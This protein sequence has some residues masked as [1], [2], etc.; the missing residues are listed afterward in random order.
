MGTIEQKREL[1]SKILG[2]SGDVIK[3]VFDTSTDTIPCIYLFTINTVGKLRKSMNIDPKYS[4]DMFLCKYGFTADLGR[5]TT[6]HIKTY[7]AIKNADLK[8]KYFRYIDPMYIS[9][10][11]TDI[12]TYFKTLKVGFN[13]EKFEELVVI[14]PNMLKGI[15]TQ[16]NMLGAV[17]GGHIKTLMNDIENMKNQMKILR[18]ENELNLSKKDNDISKKDNELNLSK[19]EIEL[20]IKDIA[21]LKKDNE[22]LTS[23]LEIERLKNK[24]TEK[25][26][27]R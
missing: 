7:N 21:L 24:Q 25:K 2:V 11:E 16:Y 27:K 10:A 18:I 19:K 4:D 9:N 5:R 22:I 20:L 14:E 15:K 3:E 1:T 26:A 6:E 17:Y 8:L 12:R 13:Y 23:K